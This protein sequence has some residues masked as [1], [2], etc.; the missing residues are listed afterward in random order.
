MDDVNAVEA[1]YYFIL[2]SQKEGFDYLAVAVSPNIHWSNKLLK[3]LPAER[4]KQFQIRPVSLEG[5]DDCIYAFYDRW[6]P[7]GKY[8]LSGFSPDK[9]GGPKMPIE[10]ESRFVD[11]LELE[12]A[13][14]KVFGEAVSKSVK[15]TVTVS[16]KKE[17]PVAE[18][19]KG[20]P[21]FASFAQM[22]VIMVAWI[23]VLV[24]SILVMTSRPVFQ[25]ISGNAPDGF[26]F[27]LSYRDVENVENGGWMYLEATIQASALDR[28]HEDIRWMVIDPSDDVVVVRPSVLD[29]SAHD[30]PGF[31]LAPGPQEIE[32]WRERHFRSIEHGYSYQWPDGSYLVYEHESDRIFG[33][34]SPTIARKLFGSS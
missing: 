22:C 8:S 11:V 29:A 4:R 20:P 1:V 28:T 12:Y 10:P 16:K 6:S 27:P 18:K 31:Q 21:P 14:E 34:L 24:A 30:K 19:P 13:P 33:R 25:E 3:K 5:V 26:R 17:A 9:N 32:K 23:V 7:G 2:W 15:P